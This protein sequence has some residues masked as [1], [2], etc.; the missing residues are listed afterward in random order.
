MLMLLAV[1]AGAG[2]AVPYPTCWVR[3]GECLDRNQ[4]PLNTQD[5]VKPL[6]NK[7]VVRAVDGAGTVDLCLA[8]CEA[9]PE[10]GY[11]T[12]YHPDEKKD[13]HLVGFN[14][15]NSCQVNIP[16]C[17]LVLL[18]CEAAGRGVC[19]APGLRHLQL[20]LRGRLPGQLPSRRPV[21]NIPADRPAA[22]AG[23]LGGPRQ[24]GGGRAEGGPPQTCRVRQKR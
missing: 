3:L 17:T 10:C 2:A 13:C 12:V 19:S 6:V 18:C 16:N 9:E 21:L 23:Q 22:A 15:G 4:P 11:F 20:Q 1:V 8:A 5:K 7:N 24:P 14:L